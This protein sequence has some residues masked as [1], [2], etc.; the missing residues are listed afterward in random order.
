MTSFA[1]LTLTF[2]ESLVESVPRIVL[3]CPH[4]KETSD[5]SLERQR[6]KVIQYPKAGSDK[7][8]KFVCAP[9]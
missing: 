9:H 8:T 3:I 5:D 1:S 6:I 2:A 4:K 7:S